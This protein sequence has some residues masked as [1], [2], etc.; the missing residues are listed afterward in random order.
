M[1]KKQGLGR[2]LKS[3]INEN[4]VHLIEFETDD[5]PASPLVFELE[6]GKIR[7]NKEQPRKIFDQSTLEELSASIKEHGILQ[8]LVIKPEDGGYTIIAGERRFRAACLAGLKTVPVIIKDLPRKDVLEIALIENVQR[9]NLNPIEEAMAYDKLIKEFGLTQNEMAERIGKNR[10]TIAN[11]IRLLN[12]PDVVCQMVLDEKLSAGHAKALLG[13]SDQDRVVALA[14][15][16]SKRN[17]SVRHLEVMV[18]QIQDEAKPGKKAASVS[19]NPYLHDCEE[20]LKKSLGTAVKIIGKEKKGKI[21][22]VYHSEQEFNRLLD[23][24]HSKGGQV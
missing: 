24:M 1:A 9:E 5:T 23:I 22:I 6:I 8:P 13:I 16:T 14:E 18:R 20:A 3:L 21:E 17:I 10:A 15:D 2:G 4:S 11:R 7:P 12:L 19:R